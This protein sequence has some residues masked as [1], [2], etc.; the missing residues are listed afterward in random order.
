VGTDRP[1]D[2]NAPGEGTERDAGA[3]RDMAT[4]QDPARDDRNQD[5]ARD[6]GMAR[7]VATDR[8]YG[9][10]DRDLDTDVAERDRER[11]WIDRERRDRDA[12]RMG[13]YDDDTRVVQTAAP[14]PVTTPMHDLVRWGPIWAGVIVAMAVFLVLQLLLFATRAV[15]L[16]I[17]PTGGSAL[18]WW[19]AIA[20]V[21][22]F[23]IGGLVAGA[24]AHWKRLNDGLIQGIVMWALATIG[25]VLVSSV[26]VGNLTSSLGG[27]L[28]A[29]AR[30][31]DQLTSGSSVAGGDI[32]S[33]RH[34]AAWACVF[35]GITLVAAAVGALIGAKLWPRRRRLQK[36]AD[37]MTT[38]DA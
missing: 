10:G 34:T 33:A 22:S 8:E 21:V 31:R 4:D 26:A 25:L 18:P 23:F 32:T 7:D 2:P 30:L 14:A 15:D 27:S 16:N 29:I 11:E 38:I 37:A 9:R 5:M 13:R 35:L 28:G 20:A 12:R 24:T 36:D 19:T 17:S 3:Q 1:V 6:P